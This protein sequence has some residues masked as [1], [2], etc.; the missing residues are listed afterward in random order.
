MKH[1]FY[2]FCAIIAFNSCHNTT[3][4]LTGNEV[5]IPL[6]GNSYIT[7]K[8]SSEKIVNEGFSMWNNPNTIFST[9]FK[10][11]N[12]NS[13]LKL[14]L[15]Y[16][17]SAENNIIEIRCKDKQFEVKL[18][19]ADTDSII[20]IGTI[21][22]CT[23][24]YVRVDFQGKVLNGNTYAEASSLLVG[25]EDSESLLFVDDFSFYW[26]RRGPS[27]H[28]SYQIPKETTAE[29]F[30]NEVTVPSGQDPIGSYFM[31]NGF[32]EGYFGMQVNSENERRVLFSVWSP[33]KTDNPKEIPDNQKIIL[34]KKGE[35]VNTGEFGNE[36]SG[37]Q[38]YYVYNWIAGNTY[39]F[40]THIRPADNGY[41]EY[42]SYF[43]APEV[44]KWKLIAQFLRPS[45][46]T[47][48]TRPHS[49]LE[50]FNSETGHIT[51]MAEY[52]NQWIYTK[53]GEWIELTNG[54][55]T[56][57]NTAKSNVRVDYKGGVNKDGFFLQNCGF[58]NDNT[59]IGNNFERK[60]TNNKPD[61]NW[62]DLE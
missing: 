49:F 51:R 33:F 5:E 30:Y 43:F 41:S 31:A 42:T 38:S 28:M 35:N 57:D 19:K 21:N 55:F 34:T 15:K 60:A 44:G 14:F 25:S 36:G 10:V 3:Q 61:I 22:N 37:G 54:K 20:Y 4:I 52:N 9:Y 48:Y 59:A 26:G 7:N 24:E 23:E 11:N 13:N 47:Y 12:T 40:L 45:T 17:S 32:G 8:A 50:N 6:G 27:V 16:K 46:N 18:P 2:I 62:N 1:V 56:A 29:W 39:K 58:F 53:D